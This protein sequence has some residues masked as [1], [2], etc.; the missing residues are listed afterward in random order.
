M[1]ICGKSIFT[2]LTLVIGIKTEIGLDFF[3]MPDSLCGQQLQQFGAW[4]EQFAAQGAASFECAALD[5]VLQQA[6]RSAS[7]CGPARQPERLQSKTVTTNREVRHISS[8]TIPTSQQFHPKSS[9]V[10][11]RIN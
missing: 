11:P 1:P 6:M 5:A 7:R 4:E 8:E 10:F 9:L 2:W 3:S